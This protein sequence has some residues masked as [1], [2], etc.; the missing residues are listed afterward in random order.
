MGIDRP[1]R[2]SG[3]PEDGGRAV[4]PLMP[5]RI[6]SARLRDDDLGSVVAA[7]GDARELFLARFEASTS[8]LC[9]TFARRRVKRR[10]A[11]NDVRGGG[12]FAC[13]YALAAPHL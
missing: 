4:A 13:P 7:R 8:R 9:S 12:R 10:H 5:A 11:F 1:R 2:V 3:G 6:A